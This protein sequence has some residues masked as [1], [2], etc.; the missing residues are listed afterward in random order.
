MFDQRIFFFK[1]ENLIPGC[2]VLQPP[3]IY[4]SAI[5]RGTLHICRA[6]RRIATGVAKLEAHFRL[7][8]LIRLNELC[9]ASSFDLLKGHR[10]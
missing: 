2:T 4:F 6:G 3:L 10:P 5:D 8:N 7:P 9:F 1:S